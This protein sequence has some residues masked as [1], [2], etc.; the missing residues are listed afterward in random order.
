MVLNVKEK[1]R[2]LM[3]FNNNKGGLIMITAFLQNFEEFMG[4]EKISGGVNNPSK[5]FYISGFYFCT[6][7]FL[8]FHRWRFILNQ[9]LSFFVFIL[10]IKIISS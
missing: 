8:I 4:P 2:K 9:F 10:K 6:R 7:I 1:F 5:S 3:D